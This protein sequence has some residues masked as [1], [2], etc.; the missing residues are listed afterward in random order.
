LTG[1]EIADDVSLKVKHRPLF[2]ITEYVPDIP[3]A[4]CKAQ[5]KIMVLEVQF[6]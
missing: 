5:N 1:K 6:T 3:T 2:F 4:F